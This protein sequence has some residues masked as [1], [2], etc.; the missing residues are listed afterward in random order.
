MVVVIVVAIATVLV[1]S[2]FADKYRGQET[3]RKVPSTPRIAR[4]TA[5]IVEASYFDFEL[6]ELPADY[7]R[8]TGRR[9]LEVIDS[10]PEEEFRKAFGAML[11]E[12]LTPIVVLNEPKRKAKDGTFV[13]AVSFRVAP[14]LESGVWP[15]LKVNPRVFLNPRVSKDVLWRTLTHESVHVRQF[16]HERLPILPP[17]VIRE[18]TGEE[19]SRYFEIEAGAHRVE[20]EVATRHG[21]PAVTD[22]DVAYRDG[23]VPAMRAAIAKTYCES[24]WHPIHC[25]LFKAQALKLP[26]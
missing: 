6:V 1:L 14:E 21:W 12:G 2:A 8:L 18:Y 24:G 26:N 9:V 25:E 5:P 15:V 10:H 17:G 23:G 7:I 13:A 11:H 19:A 22:I 20:N 4:T 3:A 16:L